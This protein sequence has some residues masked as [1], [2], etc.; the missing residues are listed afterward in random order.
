LVRPKRRW[1]RPVSHIP[2]IEP[3]QQIRSIQLIG[4]PTESTAL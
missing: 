3:G 2:T 4:L 1:A